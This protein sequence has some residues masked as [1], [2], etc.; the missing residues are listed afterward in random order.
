MSGPYMVYVDRDDPVPVQSVAELDEL[1]DRVAAAPRYQE[2]P[3]VADIASP[4]DRYILQILL[5][6]TDV[7]FLI[8][9][10]ADE[11]VE[12]SV[13]T[14]SVDGDVVFNY[15]GS[16]TDAYDDTII[17]VDVARAAT[18]EFIQTGHRPGGIEWKIPQYS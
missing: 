15:G 4:D 17:P 1:L 3:V 2:F 13:G 18:R 16:R 11:T 10:I 14:V 6:R 9:N 8:W 12:A 7:S 5:G